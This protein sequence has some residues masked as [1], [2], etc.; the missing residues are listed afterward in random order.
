M[1]GMFGMQWLPGA[2]HGMYLYR[3]GYIVPALYYSSGTVDS[4]AGGCYRLAPWAGRF[5]MMS[6]IFVVLWTSEGLPNCDLYRGSN[7]LLDCFGDDDHG[8]DEILTAARSAVEAPG[9]AMPFLEDADDG[10]GRVIRF[11]RIAV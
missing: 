5:R 1:L 8:P 3:Y 10:E 9:E 2:A 11:M 6:G 7:A 4:P